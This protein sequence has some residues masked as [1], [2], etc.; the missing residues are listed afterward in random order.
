MAS[1]YPIEL[2]RNNHYRVV[3]GPE[4]DRALQAEGWVERKTA[5][6]QYVAYNSGIPETERRGPG[7]PKKVEEAEP[8]MAD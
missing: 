3:W 5:G 1:T 4:E 6:Q 8:L 2:Y 7:R